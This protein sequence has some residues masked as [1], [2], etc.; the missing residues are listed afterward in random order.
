MVISLVMAA[1]ARLALYLIQMGNPAFNV[2]GEIWFT[3]VLIIVWFPAAT[4]IV[5]GYFT[6]IRY[7]YLSQVV[8]NLPPMFTN[9]N[10][11]LW[12]F[13]GGMIMFFGASM[14]LAFMAA[15]NAYEILMIC[16]VG[17]SLTFVGFLIG[18]YRRD[19][20]ITIATFLD[21]TFGLGVFFMPFYLP[22]LIIG[23]F[24]NWRFQRSLVD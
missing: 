20:H 10:S 5:C 14:F 9:A 13:S 23:A 15:E 8:R 16:Y 11:C 22:A 19:R 2:K 1:I 6:I 4:A 17:S 12:R 3:V 21:V 24:R 18:F 7:P